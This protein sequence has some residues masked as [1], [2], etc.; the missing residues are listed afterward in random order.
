MT[1]TYGC[2]MNEHGFILVRR[3]YKSD[4]IEKIANRRYIDIRIT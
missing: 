1:T 2:H 4:V 3:Q